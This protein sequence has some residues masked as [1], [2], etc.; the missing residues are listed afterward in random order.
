MRMSA[1]PARTPRRTLKAVV[2][3]TS[4]RRHA[5]ETD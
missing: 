5:G 3:L 1:P 2:R 4:F